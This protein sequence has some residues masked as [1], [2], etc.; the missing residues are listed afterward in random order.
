MK[1]FMVYGL[2]RSGTNYVETLLPHN[3]KDISLENM[4]YPRSLPVH[5]H[6]RLYDEMYY[7]PEQKYLN[8]FHYPHFDDFDAHVK[9]LTGKD[10]LHYVVVVKEPYSWYISYCNLAR[11]NRWPSYLPKWANQHYMID[12]SLFCKKWLE[13]RREAPEKILLLRYEDILKDLPGNLEKVRAQFG[14]EKIRE[15]YQN[16]S[17]VDMS[18]RFTSTRRNYYL[19]KEFLNLFTDEELYVLTENL[20]QA[21]VEELG[22]ELVRR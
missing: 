16:F 19:K 10:E 8:N 13:F 14:L 6:F 15:E 22:Y 9:R 5:K 11:K 7:V 4:G 17:K 21:V 18:K 3:F 2:Q 1:Y 20:D 12:Y